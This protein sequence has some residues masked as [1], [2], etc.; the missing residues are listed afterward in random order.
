MCECLCVCVCIYT[1]FQ[2]VCMCVCV[3]V[4]LCVQLL[5]CPVLIPCYLLQHAIDCGAGTCMFLV[6]ESSLIV[7]LRGSRA[8]VWGSVYLDEHG[9]EDKDLR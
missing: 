4:C 3:C 2:C 9:E 5:T 6:I 7:I 1:L 8:A